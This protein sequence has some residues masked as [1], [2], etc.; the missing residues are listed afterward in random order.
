MFDSCSSLYINVI[1]F[2]LRLPLPPKETL[3]GS[4]TFF[5]EE[6]LAEEVHYNMSLFVNNQQQYGDLHTLRE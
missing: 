5:Q 3:Q 1:K 6:N 2:P 4:Q